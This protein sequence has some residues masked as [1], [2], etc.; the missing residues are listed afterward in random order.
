ML[1]ITYIGSNTIVLQSPAIQNMID[2]VT[3]YS[4]FEVTAVVNCCPDSFVH[5][6]LFSSPTNQYIEVTSDSIILKPLFFGLLSNGDIDLLTDGVYKI[7]INMFYSLNTT[8]IHEENC[9][10]VDVTY[11]CKVAAYL[12]KI[13]D[14]QTV[15]GQCAQNVT[16]LHYALT[17]GSNCACYCNEMCTAFKELA[18]LINVNN[19]KSQGCGC[20]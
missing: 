16:L 17:N 5:E 14:V 1:T 4:K 8:Y 18:K 19:P 7:G 20:Q 2:N 13:T 10:F 6:F 3:D 15:D 12:D 9:S 11:K